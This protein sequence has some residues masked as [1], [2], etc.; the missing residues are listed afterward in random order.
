[1]PVTAPCE[2]WVCDRSFTAIAGSNPPVGFSLSLVNV[3]Y[4]QVDVSA[5]DLT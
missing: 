3:V 2:A 4:L 5:T 1:M